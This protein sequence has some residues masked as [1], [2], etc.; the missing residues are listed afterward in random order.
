MAPLL[1]IDEEIELLNI[2]ETKESTPATTVK[3]AV[4][5]KFISEY[6]DIY[7]DIY[8]GK[9]MSLRNLVIYGYNVPSAWALACH[10]SLTRPG[11]DFAGLPKEY[12]YAV[13]S[14]APVSMPGLLNTELNVTWDNLEAAVHKVWDSWHSEHAIA[15]RDAHNISHDLGTGVVIQQMAPNIVAAGVL[16]THPPNDEEN[17]YEFYP[18]VEYVDGVG[19]ALVSGESSGKVA[20]GLE[21]WY[22]S[23]VTSAKSM[24]SKFGP[25]DIEWCADKDGTVYFVQQRAL[26]F[27][28]PVV[29]TVEAEKFGD[30]EVLAMFK[31]IGSP[32][33]VSGFIVDPSYQGDMSDKILYV[34]SFNPAY[35]KSMMKAKAII[36]KHGGETCHAAILG[37][38]MGKASVSGNTWTPEFAFPDYY[39][40]KKG[41]VIN[42]TTGV[43]YEALP[44]DLIPTEVVTPV[45]ESKPRVR[46]NMNVSLVHWH[47]EKILFRFYTAINQY[48][49]KDITEERKNEV[50][51]EIANILSSY[52][53]IICVGEL[54]HI[55]FMTRG[56]GITTDKEEFIH[57]IGRRGIPLPKNPENAPNRVT[58]YEEGGIPQP[59]SLARALEVLNLTYNG[60]SKFPWPSSYGGRKWAAI[61]KM[62]QEYLSGELSSTLFVDMAFNLQHNGGRAF[63]KFEWMISRNEVMN[64]ML[65]AKKKSYSRLEAYVKTINLHSLGTYVDFKEFAEQPYLLSSVHLLGPDTPVELL[66]TPVVWPCGCKKCHCLTCF[67]SGKCANDMC[68]RCHPCGCLKCGCE[69]CF[70]NT[71]KGACRKFECTVCTCDCKICGCT[72]CLVDGRCSNE[73]C[74]L[75]HPCECDECGCERCYQWTSGNKCEKQSCPE[76]ECECGECDC[77]MCNPDGDCSNE[78]C[79]EC[80]PCHCKDCGCTRCFEDGFCSDSYCDECHPCDCGDCGCERCFADGN[81]SDSDC[82]TCNPCGGCLED[83]CTQCHQGYCDCPKCYVDPNQTKLDLAEVEEVQK[84]V[85]CPCKYCKAPLVTEQELVEV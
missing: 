48:H 63:N 61:T 78:E 56:G 46:P 71:T 80:H 66:D 26:K 28:K 54:R 4:V 9:A 18:I 19:E 81:C 14:G 16:F 76:C 5:P 30:R 85:D 65:D 68:Y 51:D 42:G 52:F 84:T 35:Y 33:T 62:V 83:D 23:L 67:P 37:R 38:E 22:L 25:S 6:A 45:A 17:A 69:K 75:C 57:E 11:L 1:L 40:T 53:Y 74:N 70:R 77:S 44:E 21:P 82:S 20:N 39:K 15:Y 31:P 32:V 2:K 55:A 12:L 47:A 27:T 58:F 72:K 49:E 10:H 79:D 64:S 60:F 29:Q 59:E 41:V 24:L 43:I 34:D 36:C 13:R 8:G 3:D 50:V 7:R 73:E